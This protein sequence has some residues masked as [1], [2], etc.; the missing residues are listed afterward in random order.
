MAT[1]TTIGIAASLI[2]GPVI[3]LFFIEWAAAASRFGSQPQ[4]FS[5]DLRLAG[6]FIALMGGIV[7]AYG[8]LGLRRTFTEAASKRPLSKRAVVGFRRFARVE[9]LMVPIGI[10][11]FSA[12]GYV[13]SLSDNI[14]GGSVS[15]RFGT[16]ELG[17][18]FI[19]LL[20]AFA[21][22]VFAEGRRAADEN[23][24]FL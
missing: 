17:A 21:A 9:L 18:F 15:I 20:L 6:A 24:S 19:A 14:D 11:Q 16:P 4:S 1:L 3:W 2:I 7:R 22:E 8:L 23:A 5:T 13:V 12:F 10:V